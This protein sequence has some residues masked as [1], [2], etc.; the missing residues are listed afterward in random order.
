MAALR[1]FVVRHGRCLEL[2]CDQGPNF[3]GAN[4]LLKSYCEKS[5][6]CLAIKWR[7]N[8]HLGDIWENDEKSVKTLLTQLTLY[9]SLV[10]YS[11]SSSRVSPNPYDLTSLMPGHFLTN[12]PLTAPPDEDSSDRNHNRLNR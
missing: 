6:E 1:R 3:V 12:E 7:P 2:Y 4:K 11:A 10:N 9:V 8:P 5:A